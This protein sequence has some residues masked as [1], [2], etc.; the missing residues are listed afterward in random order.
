LGLAN[1]FPEDLSADVAEV[2][3]L[4]L[5]V[6]TLEDVPSVDDSLNALGNTQ[7]NTDCPEI[8]HNSMS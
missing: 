1:L 6:E 8:R 2:T 4:V 3:V 5:W 7:L